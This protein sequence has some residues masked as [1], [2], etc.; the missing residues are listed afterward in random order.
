[1]AAPRGI[2][3]VEDGSQA[4]DLFKFNTGQYPEELKDLMEK[5]NDDDIAEKWTGPY[6][7]D[8]QGL[9]DPVCSFA[10]CVVGD[11]RGYTPIFFPYPIV[12]QLLGLW[13]GVFGTMGFRVWDYGIFLQSPNCW[14]F[15]NRFL[16]P[17]V[18]T[19]VALFYSPTIGTLCRQV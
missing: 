3:V 17:K 15:G 12:V 10:F 5:P 16:C 1:I 14:Y 13:E 19:I 6:L 9:D 2:A 11:Y 7:K 4:I 18:G 8:V